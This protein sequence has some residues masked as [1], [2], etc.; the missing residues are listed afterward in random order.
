MSGDVGI[1]PA[2]PAQQ[3]E[4]AVSREQR[5]RAMGYAKRLSQ[6]PEDEERRR[7]EHEVGREKAA[8]HR[9]PLLGGSL[10]DQDGKR[11]A[12][13]CAPDPAAELGG[14]QQ[15]GEAAERL[16]VEEVQK[17]QRKDELAAR[18]CDRSDRCQAVP[19]RLFKA[20][21]L[22]AVLVQESV[23]HAGWARRP[24]ARIAPSVQTPK[25]MRL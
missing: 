13:Q 11:C 12:E 24:W 9:L 23:N 16:D 1:G 3:R 6:G 5:G 4:S 2:K 7:G 22:F 25:S 19:K 17:L 14:D 21:V 10:S 20:G 8:Q 18:S 15:E